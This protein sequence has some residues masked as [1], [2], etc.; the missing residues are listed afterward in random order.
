VSEAF[1]AALTTSEISSLG[2]SLPVC[3]KKKTLSIS[4]SFHYLC[5]FWCG[6]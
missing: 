4:C 5:H 3:Q 1:S 6:S 2:H